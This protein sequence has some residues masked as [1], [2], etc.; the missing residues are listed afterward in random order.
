MIKIESTPDCTCDVLEV[1]SLIPNP[2]FEDMSCCPS[3]LNQLNCAETWVQ[4]SDPTT[5]YIHQCGWMG[6][7]NIPPPEPFPDGE[8]IVGFKNG[9][10]VHN[11]EEL[12]RNWKEYSGACLSSTL[13][14]DTTYRFEFEVGFSDLRFSPPIEITLFGTPSCS[15]LP[16]GVNND[17]LGCPTNGPGW[18]Q[19]GSRLVYA[20]SGNE[21]VKTSIEF[22]PDQEI[23]AIAIGPP[24]ALSI[25][26]ESTYY[27]FDNLILSDLESFEIRITEIKHPCNQDVLLQ[28]PLESN[29]QYQWFKNKVALPDETTYIL[30]KTYGEGCYQVRFYD[31]TECKLTPEYEFKIPIVYNEVDLSVCFEE[32]YEFGNQILENSGTYINTFKNVNNCDSTVTL[33]LTILPEIQKFIAAKIFEGEC[34]KSIENYTFSKQGEHTAR[35]IS[36][37]GCDSTILLSLE[38]YKVYFPNVF[39]PINDGKNDYFTISGAADLKEIN[40]VTIYDR[41]GSEVYTALDELPSESPGWDGK[42]HDQIIKPGIYTYITKLLM[43]DGIERKFVGSVLLL[44]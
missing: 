17:L 7:R 10:R 18:T 5:N 25:G 30:S 13:L 19:L 29:V 42:R 9:R 27:F 3:D 40:E 39:T 36:D 44:N 28:V 21:W 32:S 35:V 33:N 38:Y 6:W 43:D 4:A 22:T 2:S 11:T 16:F 20:R 31:Q 8:A 1:T 12:E 26:N 37:M 34:Y 24:C 15:N 41:W 14:A 23:R